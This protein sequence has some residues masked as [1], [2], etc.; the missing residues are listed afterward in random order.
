ML[1]KVN[2]PKNA[3]EFDAG[4]GEGVWAE[5]DDAAAK[6]YEEDAVG[7]KYIGILQ[8]DSI[9][10]P[11]LKVG[12]EITFELRGNNRPIAILEQRSSKWF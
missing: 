4:L 11:G 8:N 9:Q 3:K 1:I 5:I 6:A 2:L 10:Y 7:G 12:A